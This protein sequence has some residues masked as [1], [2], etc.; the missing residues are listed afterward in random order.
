MLK[1]RLEKRLYYLAQHFPAVLLIGPRQ[2]GKTTLARAVTHTIPSKYFDLELPAHKT[3]FNDPEL[4]LT[5]LS[6]SLVILDEIQHTPEL[7]PTLR[8]IIDARIA[9][10]NKHGHFLFLGSASLDLLRQT[11]ESLAGRIA[12]LELGPFDIT[13]VHKESTEQLWVRGGFPNSFLAED[14]ALSMQWRTDFI[15]TYLERD[16]PQFGIHTPAETLRRLFIM[17]AHHQGGIHNAASLARNLA[18]DGKTIARY[19]DLFTDLLL[20]R[21]L[22][23]W[24][25]NVGKRITKS[26]KLYVRDSGILHALLDIPDHEH[27]LTHPILG[28]SWEGFVIENT[29]L[30]ADGFTPYYYRTATGNEIDLL[31][32]RGE[33][34]IACEIKRTLAPSISRGF[35]SAAQD[36]NATERYYLYPGKERFPLSSNTEALPISDI[37]NIFSQK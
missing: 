13:E 14:D 18:V 5:P 6:H 22:P 3:L 25:T 24:H 9:Q 15:R 1:R 10:G 34:R 21:R 19:V 7:F 35:E 23:T 36:V 29:I 4:A 37:P 27:L 12:H 20:I 26:P 8:G 17:L 31:L 33:Q 11:S 32:V 2:V 28:A 30:L 16:I